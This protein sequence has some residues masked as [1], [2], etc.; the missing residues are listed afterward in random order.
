MT[1]L[2][3]LVGLTLLAVGGDVLIRGAV[4][5]AAR[6]GVSPLF[7]GLV[8]VGFGT[9]LPEL[10]TSITATLN[11]SPGLVVG[12]VLGSN[13]ANIFLILGIAALIMPI[14]ADPKSFRRDG[15]MLAVA[16]IACIAVALTGTFSRLAGF[17]FF[18]SLISYLAY[19]YIKESRQP[20]ASAVLH[21]E[22]AELVSAP[23]SMP[24]YQLILLTIGGFVMIALGA[25]W[26]VTGSIAIARDF[27]ISEEIIGLTI[28]AIGTSLPELATCTAAALRRH[29]D[30]AFG[31][32][33]GSNLFNILGILGI[34]AL[35]QPLEIPAPVLVYDI[36]VF[37]GAT[38]LMLFSAMSGF[39]VTRA[40]GGIFVALY[41]GYTLFLLT[42]ALG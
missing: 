7:T 21:A 5:T 25:S 40:E 29:T 22:E 24:L 17:I 18:I 20:D 8:L 1:F 11:E 27:G 41:V 34:T 31:N 16:T 14:P 28:V 19:T 39:R 36:W 38:A 32:V 4:G 42:R 9:S 13:I 35:V 30:V 3:I 33:L 15:P 23:S 26:T 12:N 2:L 6:L 10:V 37:A